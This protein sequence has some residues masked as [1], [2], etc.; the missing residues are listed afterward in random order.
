MQL[1]Y[2]PTHVSQG[3]VIRKEN[4]WGDN[5][6]PITCSRALGCPQTFMTWLACKLDSFYCITEARRRGGNIHTAC[7]R[8]QCTIHTQIKLQVN[9]FKSW[10]VNLGLDTEKLKLCSCK[11]VASWSKGHKV[12]QNLYPISHKSIETVFPIRICIILPLWS[13][14]R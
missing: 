10:V 14:S 3:K 9:F 13:G 6:P 4:R 1:R 8:E 12:K 11:M 7:A 2:K 5:Q